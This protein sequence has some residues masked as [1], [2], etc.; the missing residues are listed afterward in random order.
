M[1]PQNWPNTE[2]AFFQLEQRFFPEHS[3]LMELES[4]DPPI[5]F[6]SQSKQKYTGVRRYN[7]REV[8]ILITFEHF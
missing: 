8:V 7:A 5:T 4:K 1:R 3:V 6:T 2:I